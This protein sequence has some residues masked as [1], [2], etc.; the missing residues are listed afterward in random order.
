VL[1]VHS[2]SGQVSAA[3]A[4]SALVLPYL[5]AAVVCGAIAWFATR[6]PRGM[7]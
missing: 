3:V 2:A 7:S 5:A 1:S 4:S 6:I